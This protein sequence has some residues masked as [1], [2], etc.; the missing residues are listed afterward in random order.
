MFKFTIF[1]LS[2]LVVGTIA[3]D[4]HG[5]DVVNLVKDSFDTDVA[6]KP[7]FVMFFAPW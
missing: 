5:K 7:S 1:V 3:D 4:D 6:K 2:V